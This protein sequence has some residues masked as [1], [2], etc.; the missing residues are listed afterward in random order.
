MTRA[1][2]VSEIRITPKQWAH[3][4]GKWL[5]EARNP[6]NGRTQRKTKLI[7]LLD[8]M[9][10][11]T[12]SMPSVIRWHPHMEAFC[13]EKGKEVVEDILK[14]VWI[15]WGKSSVSQYVV[16]RIL[17]PCGLSFYGQIRMRNILCYILSPLSGVTMP[18]SIFKALKILR[19]NPSIYAR[20]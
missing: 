14:A 16:C 18:T 17:V 8:E 10:Q 5:S 3:L 19:I 20:S 15:L 12:T 2:C 1:F 6:G 4:L 7:F 11:E 9:Y 13:L